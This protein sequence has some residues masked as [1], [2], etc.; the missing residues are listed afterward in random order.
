M[1]DLIN[2]FEKQSVSVYEKAKR[3]IIACNEITNRY[4]LTLTETEA[5]E[6]AYMRREALKASGRTEFSGGVLPKLIYA[7]CDSPYIDK[8]N[9]QTVLADLQDAFYACKSDLSD[10]CTDD[11]IIEFTVKI[12]N[13]EAQGSVDYTVEAALDELRRYAQKGKELKIQKEGAKAW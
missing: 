10:A 12:F 6:L 8:Q 9:Y 5:A 11:E 2:L 1:D 3:E 4:G 7:L 13:G